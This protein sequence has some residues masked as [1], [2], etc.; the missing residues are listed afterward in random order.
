INAGVAMF[1]GAQIL[2]LSACFGFALMTL[3]Q[4]GVPGLVLMGMYGLY[5]LLP[6]NIAYSVT[7]WKDIPFAGAV[8][9]FT[10]ALYRW[11][12]GLG[13]K[14]VTGIIL[15][16]GGLGMCLWRTNGWYAFAVTLAVLTLL[17]GKK[18]K[19]LLLILL[20]VLLFTWVL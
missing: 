16:L 20:A 11:F 6:Y 7:L 12:A 17:L 8:L 19:K 10:T 4:R 1:H 14:R 13:R 18:Q 5:A 3:Y 9:V 2:F 15:V